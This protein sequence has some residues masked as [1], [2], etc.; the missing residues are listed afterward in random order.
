MFTFI[1]FIITNRINYI[2]YNLEFIKSESIKYTI[3][4]LLKP[5]W[6]AK[7]ERIFIIQQKKNYIQI[8][9]NHIS[10]L[11]KVFYKHKKLYKFEINHLFKNTKRRYCQLIKKINSN[12]IVLKKLF[13]IFEKD[14]FTAENNI[15]KHFIKPISC[16]SPLFYLIE[17]INLTGIE[18]S[19]YTNLYMK[20]IYLSVYFVLI[21]KKLLS[22]SNK[23]MSQALI[24]KISNLF[25]CYS[26]DL[27]IIQFYIS[28][29][30]DKYMDL[31]N[32]KIELLKPFRQIIKP[33]K[34][35]FKYLFKQIRSVLYHKNHLGYWRT[36]SQI[37]IYE[38]SFM[39]YKLLTGW[40][41]YYS[42]TL[43]QLELKMINTKVDGLIH[44]W[45]NK[46]YK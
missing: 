24:N 31:I 14:S 33:S 25:R 21:N 16:T 28:K 18:W 8:I 12:S 11:I 38:T 30:E 29:N 22:I 15:S 10:K 40:Y 37:T 43:S 20:N 42:S 32:I 46:K 5:D 34:K 45:H 3:L 23:L 27:R 41:S 2:N 19:I 44:L 17:S 7:V 6:L 35:S 36:N 4:A 9:S 13:F 39:V 1:Y 26:I